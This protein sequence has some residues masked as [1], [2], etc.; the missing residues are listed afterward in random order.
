MTF[1]NPE[2][3]IIEHS[4]AVTSLAFSADGKTLV[5]GGC[6]QT[7]IVWDVQTG[8]MQRLLRLHAAVGDISLTPDGK[9]VV[10][11]NGVW[12]V[13]TGQLI[14]RSRHSIA[15]LACSPDGKLLA[16]STFNPA[17]EGWAILISDMATG[18]KE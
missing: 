6:D 5:S 16:S 17:G 4:N 2:L 9:T 7:S 12:D 1:R 11:D 8:Q 3:V 18:R 13:P 10:I 15:P 14:R